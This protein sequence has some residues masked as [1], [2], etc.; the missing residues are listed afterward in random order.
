MTTS[1][2]GSEQSVWTSFVFAELSQTSSQDDI[3]SW[4]AVTTRQKKNDHEF[5]ASK[6]GNG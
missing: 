3:V 5:K 2:P 6:R 1:G 4:E